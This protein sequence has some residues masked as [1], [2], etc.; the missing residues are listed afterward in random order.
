MIANGLIFLQYIE[1]NLSK[2]DKYHKSF[3]LFDNLEE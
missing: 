3:N 2:I 1:S